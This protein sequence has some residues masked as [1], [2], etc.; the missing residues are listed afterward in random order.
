MVTQLD[1]MSVCFYHEEENHVRIK[2]HQKQNKGFCV[3]GSLILMKAAVQ[4]KAAM[5]CSYRTCHHAWNNMCKFLCLWI[6][7][8]WADCYNF[9]QVSQMSWYK[10][11][12]PRC[13]SRW[14]KRKVKWNGGRW[15]L[16]PSWWVRHAPETEECAWQVCVCACLRMYVHVCVRACVR[17]YGGGDDVE[18]CEGSL[19]SFCPAG[20]QKSGPCSL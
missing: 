4:M 17:L 15:G 12:S 11:C 14:N 7:N 8:N 10:V 20:A 9:Q 13:S 2:L 3:W 6:A 1:H 16:L 18:V 5:L 19:L